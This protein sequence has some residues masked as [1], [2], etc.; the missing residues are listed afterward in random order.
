MT[1]AS[2]DICVGECVAVV[3]KDLAA[4]A[5]PVRAA[6]RAAAKLAPIPA[7]PAG[8]SRV[9]CAIALLEGHCPSTRHRALPLTA[10]VAQPHCGQQHA[11]QAKAR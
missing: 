4:A 3:I 7:R 10:R 5:A 11:E 8:T 9:K 6:I 1:F 2:P